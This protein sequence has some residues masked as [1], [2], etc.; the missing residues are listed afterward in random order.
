VDIKLGN[1]TKRFDLKVAGT[2]KLAM[3]NIFTPN[4]DNRNDIFKP[5]EYCGIANGT[6]VIYNRWGQ[7]IFRTSE[8]GNGWNGS[9]NGK[10]AGGGIYYWAIEYTDFSNARKR[11]KGWVELIN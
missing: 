4:G 9:V 8:P 1:C 11:R 5:I 6:L 10:K 7:A 3:P 2:E